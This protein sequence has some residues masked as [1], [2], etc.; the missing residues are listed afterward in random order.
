M[1]HW[2]VGFVANVAKRARSSYSRS[3]TIAWVHSKSSKE[4]SDEGCEDALTNDRK[5]GDD[6]KLE[7]EWHDIVGLQLRDESKH[8]DN[9]EKR[10]SDLQR[11]YTR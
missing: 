2:R 11:H 7:L 8:R 9:Y 4:D 10:G 1:A 5:V 6:E 3:G